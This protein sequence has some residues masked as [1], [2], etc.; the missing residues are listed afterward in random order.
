MADSDAAENDRCENLT[1]YYDGDCPSCVRDRQMYETL[2]GER[3]RQVCW[4]DI[5][6]QEEVLKREGIDP[7]KALT[8]LHVRDGSGQVVSELDA[9]ILLMGRIPL[10]KPLARLIGLPLIRPWLAR[11]YHRMVERRLRG[12]GRI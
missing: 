2:A 7:R 9:Y 4:F 1:V 11:A 6:G 12:S 8:E 10:L 5:T 3:G